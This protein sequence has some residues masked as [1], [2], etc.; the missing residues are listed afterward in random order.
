MNL[1]SSV[2]DRN[3][4]GGG[5]GFCLHL[6]LSITYRLKTSR[7]VSKLLKGRWLII[8]IPET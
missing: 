4:I 5:F 6:T 8:G 3:N 2:I 7:P 1:F